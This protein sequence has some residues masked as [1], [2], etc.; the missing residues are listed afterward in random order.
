MAFSTEALRRMTACTPRLIAPCHRRVGRKEVPSVNTANLPS[1]IVAGDALPLLVT[2]RAELSVIRGDP[3][4][5]HQEIAIVIHSVKPRRRKHLAFRI[6]GSKASIR[7]RYVTAIARAARVVIVVAA[8]AGSHR[9]KMT[10]GRHRGAHDALVTVETGDSL[11]RMALMIESQSW[12]WKGRRGNHA[13]LRANVTVGAVAVAGLARLLRVT[14]VAVSLF[15]DEKVAAS[16]ALGRALVAALAAKTLMGGM[17]MIHAKTDS[18]RRIHDA[19]AEL[20]PARLPARPPCAP[21]DGR[22]EKTA[23]ESAPQESRQSFCTARHHRH[24]FRTT[25]A[26]PRTRWP[27][28]RL[29]AHSISKRSRVLSV[30]CAATP[31]ADVKDVA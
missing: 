5:P 2:L 13:S 20:P 12:W 22:E 31:S 19:R 24:A 17:A 7:H 21:E 1:A 11:T 26:S 9:R 14:G 4:M 10:T 27:T 6:R 23:D 30:S 18:L 25:D 28:M 15:G 16:R 8:E 3:A 29:Y